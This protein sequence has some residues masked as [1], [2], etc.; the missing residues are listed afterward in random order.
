MSS[1]IMLDE[2]QIDCY[3]TLLTYNEHNENEYEHVRLRD[4]ITS[5]SYPE[6]Y[7]WIV[8]DF[9]GKCFIASIDQLDNFYIT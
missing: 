8:E 7:W 3:G 1:K 9:N 4:T 6:D 2:P 5:A